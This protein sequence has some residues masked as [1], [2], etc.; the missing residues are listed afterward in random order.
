[1]NVG[2]GEQTRTFV[3]VKRDK[4]KRQPRGEELDLSAVVAAGS[5]PFLS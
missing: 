3:G 5:D 1:M 4:V 2:M